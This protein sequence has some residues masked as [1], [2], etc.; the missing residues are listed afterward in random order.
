MS[1]YLMA[2]PHGTSTRSYVALCGIL[3]Y[4]GYTMAINGI[5]APFIAAS[6]GL[7]DAGIARLCA[8]ISPAA[9]GALL[10]LRL[11][12]RAGRRRVLLACTAATPVAALTAAALA[13]A[14]HVVLFAL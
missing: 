12:D 14:R 2:K 10:L 8:W 13:A 5:G 11:A 6:F 1:V 3:A 9:V 4:Q 7:G